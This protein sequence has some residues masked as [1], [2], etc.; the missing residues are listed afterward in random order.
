MINELYK[1]INS[2]RLLFSWRY[3]SFLVRSNLSKSMTLIPVLGYII[4]Y[5]DIMQSWIN[6]DNYIEY[7][8]ISD[9]SRAHFIYWAAIFISIAVLLFQIFAPKPIKRFANSDEFGSE[10][11]RKQSYPIALRLHD[12]VRMAASSQ[13]LDTQYKQII[14]TS[15]ISSGIDGVT[16]KHILKLRKSIEKI[17]EDLSFLTNDSHLGG[18]SFEK[19]VDGEID[20]ESP[21]YV[22]EARRRFKIESLDYSEFK[23]EIYNLRNSIYTSNNYSYDANQLKSILNRSFE[24]VEHVESLDD[25]AIAYRIWSSIY[26]HHN[27]A[28]PYAGIYDLSIGLYDIQLKSINLSSALCSIFAYIG[29]LLFALPTGEIFIRVLLT[30]L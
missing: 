22:F 21:I 30:L 9:L 24:L 11:A 5:S 8:L 19:Y 28:I 26:R 10:N 29:V 18:I 16:N 2:I 23:D 14:K 4:I 6:I 15:L 7:S 13:K 1:K 17:K 3:S 27:E 20:L 12:E 25:N